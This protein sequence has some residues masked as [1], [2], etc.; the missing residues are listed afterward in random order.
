MAEEEKKSILER[1]GAYVGKKTDQLTDSLLFGASNPEIFAVKKS[2]K[3]LSD[4]F[5]DNP[6]DPDDYYFLKNIQE[7]RKKEGKEPWFKE[8]RFRN[9]LAGE[10][11]PSL[12]EGEGEKEFGDRWRAWKAAKKEKEQAEQAVKPKRERT[13]EEQRLMYELGKEDIEKRRGAG[14]LDRQAVEEIAGPQEDRGLAEAEQ[15]VREAIAAHR[16]VL[17]YKGGQMKKL[18]YAEGGEPSMEDQME[19]LA[20]SVPVSYTHLTLPTIL[21]V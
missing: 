21:R 19:G 16:R 4:V 3:F 9:W 2:L 13:A 15:N 5:G 20:I 12:E 10:E 6:N 7:R 8:K 17:N 1:A 11:G 14:I 18:K